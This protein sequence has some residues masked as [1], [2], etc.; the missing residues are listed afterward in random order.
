LKFKTKEVPAKDVLQA[1]EGLKYVLQELGNAGQLD[2]KLAE[3]AFFPLA[4]QVF[5][6][7]ARLSSRCLEIAAECVTL[8]VIH[9]YQQL[10]LPELGKQLLILMS[11]LAGAGPKNQADPATDEL[12][13]AAFDCMSAV[14]K[15]LKTSKNGLTIFEDQGTKNVVDQLIYLLLAAITDSPSDLVQSSASD[16][17]SLLITTIRSRVFLASLLPRT[18][19]SLTRALKPSTKARRTQKVLTSNLKALRLILNRTLSDVVAVNSIN[20]EEKEI[21]SESWLKAT[22]GQVKNAL[23]QI[24]KLRAHDGALVH[25]ELEELCVMVIEECRATLADSVPVALETLIVL[26]TQANGKRVQS[27]AKHLV[28]AY[29]E[30]AEILRSNFTSLYQSLPRLMQGH[31]EQNKQR[32]L[33]KLTAMLQILPEVELNMRVAESDFLSMLVSS[34][35]NIMQESTPNAV[36]VQDTSSNSIDAMISFRSKENN[37]FTPFLL[38]RESQRE[39]VL[40]LQS[41]FTC[42]R[43]L[44]ERS[45]ISRYL[46][47]L[48]AD[49]D[50]TS[51]VVPLWLALNLLREDES[52]L[53]ELDRLLVSTDSENKQLSRSTLLADLH[54]TTLPLLAAAFDERSGRQYQWQSQALALECLIMY[55]QTFEGDSY[56]PELMDTLY[57]VLSFLGST[58][59]ILQSHAMT[60]LNCLA[61]TCQYSSTTDLLIDNVDYLVNSIAWKLN[62]YSL[63]PEAPQILRMM[64]HL[65]GA[66][67]LPYLDDLIQ[68]IFAALDSYH[69]YPEWV[70]AM[71]STLKAIVDES[72]R[73]PQLTITQESNPINHKKGE[74]PI[75]NPSDILDDLKSRKRRKLDFNRPAEEAPTKTPHRPWTNELDG[76]SFPKPPNTDDDPELTQTNDSDHLAPTKQPEDA[77]KKLSKPHTLLLSI[78]TSTIPHLSSPSPQV[79]HLL[80]GLL[81]DIS[82]LLSQDENS[83][84]PLLNAIW[85][86][87]VPRL[88][89]SQTTDHDLTSNTETA[90]NICAAADTIA[91]LCETA[92]DFLASRIEDIAQQLFRLFKKVGS[93]QGRS[94]P[95]IYT[96][97]LGLEGGDGTAGS[98]NNIKAS[99]TLTLTN[100]TQPNQQQPPSHVLRT[101]QSQLQTSLLNLLLTIT[102]HVTL[103]QDTSDE[104]MN[105]L[106]PFLSDP[107]EGGRVREVVGV[108]NADALWLYEVGHGVGKV[109]LG[110]GSGIVDCDAEVG[111]GDGDGGEEGVPVLRNG[112][113]DRGFRLVG[114]SA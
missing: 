23:L 28:I 89:A 100:P 32:A 49:S 18:V 68:S 111:N 66:Q 105:L 11:M 70:E 92:G 69:G 7:T 6:E 47:D 15:A 103:Q 75:S 17:L 38:S 46:V 87:L 83:F 56:R 30:A 20:D 94:K 53:L 2:S 24:V 26:S 60:A 108:Y 8:L 22:A 31:D 48:V 86:V 29:P 50:A 41:L 62:T 80:L 52:D 93:G 113:K 71:F 77:E 88:F 114:L 91:I 42:M 34:I 12:R 57:P 84:L 43:Q 102:S 13:V 97:R 19:S 55:A 51:R 73:R 110:G 25:A 45:S 16:V 36:E 112:L 54:A 65:C 99:V 76:P 74:T 78:A 10:L 63:S 109:G 59:T 101:S 9:G 104:I 67:L 95:G 1:L 106:L 39:T 90:Y 85:P 81:K 35:G 61:T 79:R 33:Q 72:V 64:V 37:H 58:N 98:D 44:P 107:K 40:H 4:Q 82:P 5:N 96:P 14:I 21:L 27:T 3:Y